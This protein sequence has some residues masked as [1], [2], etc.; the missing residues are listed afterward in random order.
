MRGRTARLG[1]WGLAAAVGA[2]AFWAGRWGPPVPSN[3]RWGPARF[4]AYAA[5]A[6]HEAVFPAAGQAPVSWTFDAPG[7]LQQASVAH[8]VLY[9]GGDGGTT[10]S[11]QVYALDARTGQLLWHRPLGNLVM[12]TPV[13]AEGMVFV[14]TGNQAFSPAEARREAHLRTTGVVRGTGPSAWVALDANT[15]AV[16]WTHPTRGEDMP[17]PVY[18]DGVLYGVN[19]SGDVIALWAAT[20]TVLWRLRIP[21]YVSMS[22]PALAGHLLVFAGAHPYRL[23]AVDLDT[24]RLAWSRR[25]PGTFAGADDCSVAVGGG[26]VFLEAT[27]GTA[28]HPVSTV[29]AFNLA[30]RRL[31]RR[32]LGTGTLVRDIEVGAPTVVGGRVFLGSPITRHIYALNAATGQ[33]EWTF[34]AAGPVSASPAVVGHRLYVGDG[35]GL[36]YALDADNGRLEDTLDVGQR[37]AA[38]YPLVVGRTLYQPTEGG[39]MWS[40]ALT[41]SGGFV[42][43]ALSLPVPK[44][45]LGAEVVAGARVFA[46]STWSPQHLS[47]ASCHQAGGL[48][49]GFR[50][51]RLV[52]AL[53]G[54]AAR[55]PEKTPQGLRTLDDQIRDCLSAMGVH[56]V[57]DDDPRMKALNFYLHWLASGF[58]ERP[59]TVR[60]ATSNGGC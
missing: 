5:T 27:A 6:R 35:T 41:A 12:T 11:D 30:G 4:V 51:G 43:P 46:D 39:Q 34:A 36:L 28:R 50:D 23:Y 47:C 1:G 9:V 52:P 53:V 56:G 38:D 44:G 45:P 24:R 29:F 59:G 55:Y 17:S 49:R 48:A 21:S 18:H 42:H 16:V 25:L 3:P 7:A 31:W 33:V 37:M 2:L 58:P 15:G 13:V 8:G 32:A 19:G 22:S 14:G 57:R 54:A 60:A 40:I 10:A 26:R 20:G